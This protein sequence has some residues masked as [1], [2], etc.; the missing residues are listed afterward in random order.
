[1]E[2]TVISPFIYSKEIIMRESYEHWKW[3][4][5]AL[6]FFGKER[7]IEWHRGVMK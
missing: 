7:A 6:N 1:M 5:P 4:K 3:P 2:I